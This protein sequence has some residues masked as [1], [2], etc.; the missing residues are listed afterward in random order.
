MLEVSFGSIFAAVAENVNLLFSVHFW[1]VEV[2]RATEMQELQSIISR[3]AGI[4][5]L[6]I[7]ILVACVNHCKPTYTAC[8]NTSDRWSGRV[9]QYFPAFSV[10]FW[11][12]QSM[13]GV[14]E[15]FWQTSAPTSLKTLFAAVLSF[16]TSRE[17]AMW[18][19]CNWT[20]HVRQYDLML[21]VQNGFCSTLTKYGY[22]SKDAGCWLLNWFNANA[23]LLAKTIV[24]LLLYDSPLISKHSAEFIHELLI[25][26][27]KIAY[28]YFYN[29]VKTEYTQLINGMKQVILEP[30][31]I[32]ID[33]GRRSIL[34]RYQTILWQTS[35]GCKLNRLS[36][37]NC[38]PVYIQ[39]QWRL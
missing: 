30:E 2:H 35:T 25:M 15:V 29:A 31:Y 27:V 23:F 7:I 6:I 1:A 28:Y 14:S 4:S 37:R 19:S 5:C 38:R 21:P 11:S 33:S 16:M 32:C 22:R 17:V 13:D 9:V 39:L 3:S 10:Y 20:L 18:I 8:S 24:M 12:R 26:L 36:G 34:A